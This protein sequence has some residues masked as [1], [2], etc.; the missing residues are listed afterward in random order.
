[1]TET[2]RPI[3]DDLAR[4]LANEASTILKRHMAVMAISTSPHEAMMIM[5]AGA[6]QFMINALKISVALA[7]APGREAA[8]YE[9]L[10]QVTF[11]QIR[12]AAPELVA[13]IEKARAL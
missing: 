7:A 10:V 13:E 9:Q 3:V 4:H 8:L 12:E 6:A 11:N 5:T 2:R 1:M